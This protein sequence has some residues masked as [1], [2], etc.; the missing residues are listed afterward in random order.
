MSWNAKLVRPIVPPKGKP[1][2]TLSDA[3]AY[4]LGLPEE[5]QNDPLVQA[6]TEAILMAANGTGPLLSAQA[7]MAHI[8]HGPVNLLNRGKPDRPW[9]RRKAATS[10]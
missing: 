9:M 8:V 2:V 3:R 7:G 5:R 10:K 4:I 1:I 6:G